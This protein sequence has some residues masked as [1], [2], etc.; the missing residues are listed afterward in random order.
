MKAIIVSP[1]DP[2]QFA[3][4]EREA[5][6]PGPRDLLVRVAAVSVNPVDTKVR[7]RRPG[8]IL[9]WDAAGTVVATGAEVTRFR[10]GDEV[11]Y[12]GDIGREGTNAD[13]HAVDERIVGH[14]P[15][16]LS[17]L[18]AASVPL[19][20]LTAW[21]GLFEQ[22]GARE[23]GGGTI[24]VIGAAGGVGSLVVQ[25]ARRVA[26]MT[27]VATASRGE[28]SAWVKSM[29]ADH[30]VS[31]REDIPAQIRALGLKHVDHIFCCVGTDQHFDAMAEI[32]AP[33][34]RIVS[35]VEVAGPLPV[36]KL[37]G[38]KAS[39][40][41]EL[42]FTKAMHQTSDMGSQGAILDRVAALLDEGVLTSTLT[43][44]FGVLAPEALAAAH[45]KIAAGGMIGK[46]ALSVESAP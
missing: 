45:R 11:Y 43:E 35:I 23:G 42:M 41:W 15:R 2:S 26:K 27:V 10:V 1:T 34:G 39:F 37:F 6:V 17:F 22:L 7:A 13:L 29:G 46:L 33:Q 30:V 8:R 38:K 16:T 9:G 3:V 18:H 19:T 14:K 4:A 5:P 20:A 32:I 25:L 24:L 36:G 21:E 28:S 44:D 31:H 12:A 40:G